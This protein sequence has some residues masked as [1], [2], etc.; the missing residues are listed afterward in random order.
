MLLNL[1][2]KIF[3]VV[4]SCIVADVDGQLP[5]AAQAEMGINEIWPDPLICGGIVHI[6]AGHIV[7]ILPMPG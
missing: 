1:E 2:L 5:V 6:D 7:V 4:Q 3:L